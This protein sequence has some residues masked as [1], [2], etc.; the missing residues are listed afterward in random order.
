MALQLQNYVLQNGLKSDVAHIV[1]EYFEGNHETIKLDVRA[2][3]S[4]EAKDNGMPPLDQNFIS[5]MPDLSI[6]A[7]N[8]HQQGYDFLKTLPKYE[9][10]IDI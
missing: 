10:A 3:M 5:F 4:K 9:N 6:D 7:P 1:I 8:Y 2:Y